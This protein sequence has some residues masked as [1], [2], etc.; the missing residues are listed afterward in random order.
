M[1]DPHV[2][3]PSERFVLF[4]LLIAS[5][6]VVLLSGAIVKVI[7]DRLDTLTERLFSSRLVRCGFHPLGLYLPLGFHYI[8]YG[9]PLFLPIEHLGPGFGS[10]RGAQLVRTPEVRGGPFSLRIVAFT[11]GLPSFGGRALLIFI[12]QPRAAS[13]SLTLY[14]LPILHL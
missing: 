1:T 5:A 2:R 4:A 9:S 8:S 10:G 14:C 7:A 13:V 12:L 6:Y 11:L 3:D